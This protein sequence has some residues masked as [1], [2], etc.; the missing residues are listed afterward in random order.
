MSE[1][2]D[3]DK[4][5]SL[6]DYGA[7]VEDK[8]SMI[9]TE[10]KKFLEGEKNLVVSV[11]TISIDGFKVASAV[12]KVKMKDFP[13]S[14]A[15]AISVIYSTSKLAMERSVGEGVGYALIKGKE[16]NVIILDI[17]SDYILTIVFKNVQDTRE[18]F[19]RVLELKNKLKTM[20]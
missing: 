9:E 16:Y 18:F 6:I 3:L 19:K 8:Q 4:L 20:L 7:Q 11:A 12:D 10:L 17:T 1:E 2:D 5:L 15:S 14:L 13:F